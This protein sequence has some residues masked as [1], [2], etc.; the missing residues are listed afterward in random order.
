MTFTEQEGKFHHHGVVEHLALL[1]VLHRVASAGLRPLGGVGDIVGG[2]EDLTQVHHLRRLR[3]AA[4]GAPVPS[5]G[6]TDL[7]QER[8]VRERRCG[9]T[10]L[11][12]VKVTRNQRRRLP[13]R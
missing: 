9:G 6:V 8:T 7:G 12:A 13:K 2:L 4:A 10:T 11:G 1:V 3:E 5:E